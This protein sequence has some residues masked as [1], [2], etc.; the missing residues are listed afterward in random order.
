MHGVTVGVQ[1]KSKGEVAWG[2]VGVCE[3]PFR[4]ECIMTAG[5]GMGG[6]ADETRVI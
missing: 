2:D 3:G 1:T 4:S 5:C 6:E